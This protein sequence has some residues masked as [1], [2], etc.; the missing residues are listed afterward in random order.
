[1]QCSGTTGS[2]GLILNGGNTGDF[3][4]Y[5]YGSGY[6]GG[7]KPATWGVLRNDAGP[8]SI[9]STTGYGNY[10]G[11]TVG[12][13]N[14]VGIGISNPLYVTDIQQ[15][16]STTSA[17]YTTQGYLAS[18]ASNLFCNATSF[19][20][21]GVYSG[22]KIQSGDFG[23][24]ALMLLSGGGYF[25]TNAI[26]Q[27]KDVKSD[28]NYGLNLLINPDGGYVGIGTTSALYSLDVN[29]PTVSGGVYPA[30][31]LLGNGGNGNQLAFDFHSFNRVG[32]ASAR[33]A[34]IDDGNFSGHM[35]FSTAPGGSGNNT[36]AER[37]RIL[38]SGNIGIGITNPTWGLEVVGTFRTSTSMTFSGGFGGGTRYVIVDNNGTV[39]Y[40]ATAISDS[41]LKS[42]ITPIVDGLAKVMA[43]KPVNFNWI[44][45]EY[46]GAEAEIGFLA[47]E[48]Q[49]VVP[50]V[51]RYENDNFGIKYTNLTAV[52]AKAIQ[53]L[54]AKN[55]DLE[56]KLQTAQNDIDLL[57]SRLAAIE[58]LISTNTS[59]DV[60][61]TTGGTRA[62]ALLSQV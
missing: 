53:E 13:T 48:V 34:N 55:T 37:M 3:F 22:I 21:G 14:N 30:L 10:N 38:S 2:A 28:R 57:E 20:G 58:A 62:D 16:L 45:P 54:S 43:L 7:E 35:A 32:G 59:A 52:L 18:Q 39:S 23:S 17:P 8:I 19:G 24:K 36:V 31:R 47:Q 11:L 50:E 4:F 6:T 5:Q 9:Q 46:Y 60:T 51:V 29:T 49:T 26:I 61:T 41:R 44:D 1:V 40:S 56:T 15:A 27:A 12:T 33:I 25:T 42:N